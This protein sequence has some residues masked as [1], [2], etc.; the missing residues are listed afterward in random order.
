MSVVEAPPTQS[1]TPERSPGRSLGAFLRES[2]IDTRM[3][4]MVVVLLVIWIGFHLIS[5]GTFLTPRNL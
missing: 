3:V 1:E 2:E 4:G 5:G